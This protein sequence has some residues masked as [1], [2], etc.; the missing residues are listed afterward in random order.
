MVSTHH[1]ATT[2]P[3]HHH[4]VCDC[5]LGTRG[6]TRSEKN[7]RTATGNNSITGSPSSVEIH[8]GGRGRS[9]HPRLVCWRPRH[10][11]SRRGVDSPL[12]LATVAS[13][14]SRGLR[15]PCSSPSSSRWRRR[16]PSGGSSLGHG[17]VVH[18]RIVGVPRSRIRWLQILSV[19]TVSVLAVAV[20]DG[21]ALEQAASEAA[22]GWCKVVGYR[23][24]IKLSLLIDL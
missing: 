9:R 3:P 17:A 13:P 11:R 4:L 21:Q 20:G 6:S 2:P 12:P 19:H 23:T 14:K 24:R 5:M 10:S 15:L 22:I 18:I 1:L 16:Q 7:G 8:G